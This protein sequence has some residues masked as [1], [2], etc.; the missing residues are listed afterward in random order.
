MKGLYAV[1]NMPRIHKKYSKKL[2]PYT[3]DKGYSRKHRISG[4]MDVLIKNRTQA[5]P[6]NLQKLDFWLLMSFLV[7]IML[8]TF[9]YS[10]LEGF[11]ELKIQNSIS[12]KFMANA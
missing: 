5:Q 2:A 1:C 9:S 3:D 11:F 4:F 10:K 7:K 8:K 12:N 6:T